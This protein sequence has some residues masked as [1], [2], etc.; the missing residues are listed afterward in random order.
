[1]SERFGAVVTGWGSALPDKV[2]TNADLA[3]RLDTTDEWIVA[4]SGIRERRIGGTTGALAAEAGRRALASADVEPS[5]V[6]LV[7]LATTTPD[8]T[9][10]ATA[11][12]VQDALGTGGGAFDV[13]GACA[14]FVYALLAGFGLAGIGARRVLVIG[15]DVMSTIVDQDDRGTAVLFG[16]GAGA[17]L[18]DAVAG[19]GRLLGWDTGSDGSAEHL[20][21]ADLGSSTVMEGKEVFRRA[22]RVM[23]DSA[24]AALGRAGVGAEDVDLLVPHQANARIIEAACS[25]LGIGLDRTA[26]VLEHTANT[27][28]ASIPLALVASVEAGRLH[29]G[30]LVVLVG[31]G[32]GLTWASAVLRWGP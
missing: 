21:Y 6:E 12:S 5:S 13:N 11:S 24:S 30:D 18:L 29:P 22:V 17:V 27:S 15:A 9:M 25:R 31:F 19:P 23:A 1:M 20:L 4:R 14:G 28:A 32:A 26:L 2:V 10:P 7:V 16:D 3:V 8:R